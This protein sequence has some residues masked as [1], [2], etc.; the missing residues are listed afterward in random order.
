MTD[1][2]FPPVRGDIRFTSPFG[3]PRGNYKHLGTDIGAQ[4][5]GVAGDPIFAAAAGT[6]VLQYTS[7]TYGLTA[8]IERDN[9]DGTYSYF[10]YAHLKNY[11]PAFKLSED[12]PTR[13]VKAGDEIGQMG[14][15]GLS[16]NNKPIP[17][18]SHFEQ[19][20][21]N[22]K[23]NFSGGWPIKRGAGEAGVTDDGV[24]WEK[25]GPSFQLPNGW[26]ATSDNGRM[27]VTIPPEQFAGTQRSPVAQPVPFPDAVQRAQRLN[28]DRYFGSYAPAPSGGPG[29]ANA[30]APFESARAENAGLIP[31]LDSTNTARQLFAKV[32]ASDYP[33]FPSWAGSGGA[34]SPIN[35][36]PM[37]NSPALSAPE[38]RRSAAPDGPAW[39]STQVAPSAAPALQRNAA[40]ALAN[41]FGNFSFPSTIAPS[42]S[43]AASNGSS[44]PQG[45]GRLMSDVESSSPTWRVPTGGVLGF[46]AGN[47]LQS[48]SGPHD[49]TPQASVFG[50]GAPPV[51]YLSSAQSLSRANDKNS[52]ELASG[53][54]AAAG[55]FAIPDSFKFNGDI[56]DWLAALAGVAPQNPI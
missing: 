9:G 14:D 48:P 50:T 21:T 44:I 12:L 42:V 5:P 41:D 1:T 38:Q 47:A 10:L 20:N 3:K 19:I 43:P 52:P 17:V 30:L 24:A 54:G 32:P 22:G 23:F 27:S 13:P 26:V 46:P 4:K 53:A 33:A 40:L 31:Y 11:H 18:H 25:V 29:V 16:A 34:I 28:T 49:E 36:A 2:L 35:P 56:V 37:N 51:P 7:P 15:T 55:L 6:L 39:T 8:I 45:I